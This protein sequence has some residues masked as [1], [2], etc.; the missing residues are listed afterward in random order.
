MVKAQKKFRCP[1][2]GGSLEWYLSNGKPGS[3]SEII[4]SNNATSSRIEWRQ[5]GE[6]F[7]FWKGK[8]VRK[9]D[10]SVGFYEKNGTT[11]LKSFSS[12]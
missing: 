6:T 1:Q 10:G 4:C 9:K 8:A 2:C 12:N 11:L 7:R 3:S 5:T